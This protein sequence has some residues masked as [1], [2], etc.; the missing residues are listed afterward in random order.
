ML[1]KIKPTFYLTLLIVFTLLTGS[2]GGSGGGGSTVDNTVNISERVTFAGTG[3]LGIFDPSVTRDPADGRLWMSYSSV[4]ASTFFV[5]NQHIGVGI[6]L[7]FSDDKG[8]TWTDAGIDVV[9]FSDNT[10]GPLPSANAMLNIPAGSDGTWQSETSSLVYD[11][12][13]PANE[14]WKIIWHQYLIANGTSYFVD[15]SWLAMK[16]AATPLELA[17]APS[18]KLFGGL[19]LNT[20]GEDTIAPAFSPTGGAPA[21]Q[22]NTDLPAS[23]GFDVSEL[24]NCI[25]AEPGLMATSTALYA[26]IHCAQIIP[27]PTTVYTILLKC[28]SPCSVTDANA[29]EYKGR[30][31][32]PA[33][34]TVISH[35][36]YSAPELV[37]IAGTYYLIA[38]PVDTSS[39]A[40]RYDGCRVYQ[41]TDLDLGLLSRSNGNLLEVQRVDGTAN[42]HNGACSYHSDLS[43]G[44]M[45]VQHDEP[46][47]PEIFKIYDSLV[48]IP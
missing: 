38:T 6:R 19:A 21:I 3:T 16:M 46:D 1:N 22:L 44:I 8:V 7:A 48:D 31:L 5:T 14:R 37:D 28:A 11:P 4:E 29:W 39:G 26:A 47:P 34:A 15:Y 36:H 12:G 43:N 45:Y 9:T 20:A 35:Q 2:C 30:L 18:I 40:D 24:N 33:D 17:T 23:I 41:F 10:V 32:T 27:L 25:F 13:A 42:T